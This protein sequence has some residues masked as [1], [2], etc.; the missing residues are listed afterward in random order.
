MNFLLIKLYSFLYL[1]KYILCFY[2]FFKIYFQV[3]MANINLIFSCD[4]LYYLKS[5]CIHPIYELYLYN[6]K[7]T[8]KI[9]KKLLLLFKILL[10][11]QI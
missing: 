9:I 6:Y 7:N 8:N 2:C 4:N 10:C 11:I 3:L 1:Y 5:L